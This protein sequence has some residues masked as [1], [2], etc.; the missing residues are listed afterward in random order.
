MIRRIIDSLTK[1][2]DHCDLYISMTFHPLWWYLCFDV[3]TKMKLITIVFRPLDIS[4]SWYSRWS[5]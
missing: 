1:D 5:F 2:Q 3:D 4:I